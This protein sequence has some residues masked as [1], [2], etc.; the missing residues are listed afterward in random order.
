MCVYKLNVHVLGFATG[1]HPLFQFQI[2]RKG[3]SAFFHPRLL[4]ETRS[5]FRLEEL[6]RK[7]AMAAKQTQSTVVGV[8]S[9]L[10]FDAHSNPTKPTCCWWNPIVP[11]WNKSAAGCCALRSYWDPRATWRRVCWAGWA[12]HSFMAAGGELEVLA[13]QSQN[14]WAS[15][16]KSR[17]ICRCPKMG[18]CQMVGLWGGIDP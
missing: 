2:Y 1:N 4:L 15:L 9:I 7:M 10:S 3:I 16:A 12:L 18:V 8:V 17:N 11:P 5:L 6:T 14:S 13:F